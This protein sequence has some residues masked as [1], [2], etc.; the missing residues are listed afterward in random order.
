MDYFTNVIGIKSFYTTKFKKVREHLLL[1]L[2]LV[3]I[4]LLCSVICFAIVFLAFITKSNA[5]FRFKTILF[6]QPCYST[7]TDFAKFLG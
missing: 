3:F 2:H 1:L 5:Y 6:K 4:F 7:V